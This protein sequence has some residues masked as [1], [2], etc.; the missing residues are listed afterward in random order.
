MPKYEYNGIAG[1]IVCGGD[2]MACMIPDIKTI[3]EPMSD[4]SEE[5]LSGQCLS[6]DFVCRE[7]VL[8]A[9]SGLFVLDISA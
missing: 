2:I 7:A 9:S 3:G 5:C 8:M 4:N 6:I 1:F